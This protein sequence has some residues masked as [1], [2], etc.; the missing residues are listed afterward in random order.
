MA[1]RFIGTDELQYFMS[2]DAG[3]TFMQVTEDS[4]FEPAT[5]LSTYDPTYKDRTNQP[6]FVTGVK[7][8]VEF[9]ID[10][11]DPSP[12]QAELIAKEDEI[13][14]PVDLVRVMM[15]RPV[16]PAWEATTPYIL[17]DK[18]ISGLNIYVC[19][20]AGT[21]GAA[22][23]PT[24]TVVAITDGT[25]KWDFVS[26]AEGTT[27]GTPPGF[28]AKKAT[29]AMS[30]NPINGGAGEALQ[31]TGTLSMTSDGWTAGTFNTT[32]KAFTATV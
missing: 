17:G 9:N 5:D 6:S 22:S 28:T 26:L 8:K 13:N 27:V 10:I 1:K 14:V 11:Y 23:A 32:T 12:L 24:T 30:Q 15:F 19:S 2:F 25:A 18:V 21:S 4:E 20:T 31:A 7:T 29:F 3:T 16:V